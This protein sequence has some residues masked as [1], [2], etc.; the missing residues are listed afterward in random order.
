MPKWAYLKTVMVAVPQIAPLTALMTA[1][2][3]YGNQSQGCLMGK[4]PYDH[5]LFPSLQPGPPSQTPARGSGP[6]ALK[7]E[8]GHVTSK[9]G[10][11]EVG[12]FNALQPN[13]WAPAC[14]TDC[15][16]N[17]AS[18][19]ISDCAC[20]CALACTSDCAHFWAP[21]CSTDCTHD[22]ATN[23]GC[24][25]A[26]TASLIVL[27]TVPQT[28]LVTVPLTYLTTCAT[29]CE[30]ECAPDCVT[31]CAPHCAT[32]CIF[33]C[34]PTWAH[35]WMTVICAPWAVLWK[36]LMG[37]WPGFLQ[38]YT[39]GY[40]DRGLKSIPWLQKMG[41]NQSLDILH[42]I[43]QI[44]PN[45]CYLLR[46]NGGIRSKWPEFAENIPL[47]TEPQPKL[48]PWLLESSQK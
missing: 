31:D 3:H 6:E 11:L 46:K 12:V 47:V 40:G 48:D 1:L 35:A 41:Q 18:A 38:P 42:E 21:A 43:G 36:M 30:F 8:R 10:V 2:M 44:W 23:C 17:W 45:S 37:V 4:D 22:C 27:M 7:R 13:D 25:C 29:D 19:C 26:K 20:E 16:P 14:T 39:L 24:E 28:V 9:S 32:E 5:P 15:A 33:D 34:A